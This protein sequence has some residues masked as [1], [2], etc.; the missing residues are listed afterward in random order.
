MT[1]QPSNPRRRWKLWSTLALTLVIGSGAWMVSGDSETVRN[2]RQLRL[3]MTEAE[4]FEIMGRPRHSVIL[5]R[6]TGNRSAGRAS[7]HTV[8]LFAS[9]TENTLIE[10]KN[11]MGV[12]L[13]NLGLASRGPIMEWPVQVDFRDGRVESLRRGGEVVGP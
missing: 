1:D 10:I 5:A 13:V 11:R 3:G 6:L 4:V 7:Q 8:A 12:W 9:P 2:A